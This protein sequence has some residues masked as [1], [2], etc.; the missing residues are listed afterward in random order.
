MPPGTGGPPCKAS[1]NTLFLRNSRF[2]SFISSSSFSVSIMARKNDRPPDNLPKNQGDSPLYVVSSSFLWIA[3]S[4]LSFCCIPLITSAPPPLSNGMTGSSQIL[5]MTSY[6][7]VRYSPLS[8]F[9]FLHLATGIDSHGPNMVYQ[10]ARRTP[11]YSQSFAST[12]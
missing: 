1:A 8:W 6:R 12:S 3:Q 9:G 5:Q 2:H 4:T 7:M 11:T 10:D